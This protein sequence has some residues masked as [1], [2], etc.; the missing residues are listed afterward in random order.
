MTIHFLWNAKVLL[1]GNCVS[2][3]EP[4]L[5]GYRTIQGLPRGEDWSRVSTNPCTCAGSV[6][7]TS[8]DWSFDPEFRQP[9]VKTAA[10]ADELAKHLIDFAQFYGHKHLSFALS[11]VDLP[12]QILLTVIFLSY[13]ETENC[14]NFKNV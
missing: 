14:L 6:D 3:K 4:L 11:K 12:N 5:R 9:V 8:F 13:V 2:L 10:K 1:C 7:M